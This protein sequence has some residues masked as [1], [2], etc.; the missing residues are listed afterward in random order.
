M[1]KIENKATVS[2]IEI[3]EAEYVTILETLQ[4]LLGMHM[5]LIGYYKLESDLKKHHRA[6]L[7]V[8][9]E[10]EAV[11]ENDLSEIDD[12][13]N[14]F[15][16]FIEN[17]A[18]RH[19]ESSEDTSKDEDP[20]VIMHMEDL[21]AMQQDMI[22]LTDAID[23]LAKYYVATK[24]NAPVN[25]AHYDSSVNDARNLADKVFKKWENSTLEEIG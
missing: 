11:I 8:R 12:I 15:G 5:N 17:A 10:A 9:E 21:R 20:C 13:M 3:P 24:Y 4:K 14:Q 25:K 1:R 16:G 7:H 6:Y 2:T 18:C 23:I 22:D 19:C